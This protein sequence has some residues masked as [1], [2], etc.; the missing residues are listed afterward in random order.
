MTKS[1]FAVGA[2]FAILA[3]GSGASAEVDV[4]TPWADVFVGPGGVFV[5]GPW[6][7]V[8]V[9]EDDRERV[10]RDWRKSVLAHYG[11]RGCEIEFD[12]DGCMIQRVDCPE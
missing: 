4:R 8:D 1:I 12:A 7:R 10:C 6:G 2:M 9:P 11:E 5:Q 3:F